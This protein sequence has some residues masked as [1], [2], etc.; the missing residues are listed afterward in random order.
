MLF[1][2]GDGLRMEKVK[3]PEWEYIGEC[4]EAHQ[5]LSNIE[6]G[7]PGVSNYQVQEMLPT[8]EEI[9][10][11]LVSGLA[12]GACESVYPS[13]WMPA[14]FEGRAVAQAK[15]GKDRSARQWQR[16][17]AGSTG[18]ENKKHLIGCLSQDSVLFLPD[19]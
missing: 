18:K 15:L 10:H 4:R 3:L 5:I 19:S 14:G 7:H 17:S 2:V 12:V 11:R 16:S 8:T 9:R 6:G 13:Y 1:D